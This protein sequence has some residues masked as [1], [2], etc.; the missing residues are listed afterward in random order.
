MLTSPHVA[1][2]TNYW[3]AATGNHTHSQDVGA[4]H[5]HTPAE[6]SAEPWGETHRQLSNHMLTSPHVALGT[7]YWEA[8]TGNHT[9]PVPFTGED[10][11]ALE[12][13]IANLEARIAALE[14]AG[15]G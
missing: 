5:Q 10:L 2:G 14:G 15:N 6:A 13:R 7:N 4:S 8:A 12:A 1:L 11:A 9:H 3:E